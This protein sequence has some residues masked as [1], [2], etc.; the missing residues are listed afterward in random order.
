MMVSFHWK[1]QSTGISKDMVVPLISTRSL[2]DGTKLAQTGSNRISQ[3]IRIRIMIISNSGTRKMFG[4]SPKQL[5][6]CR[7]SESS[8]PSQSS[9]LKDFMARLYW[10]FSDSETDGDSSIKLNNIVWISFNSKSALQSMLLEHL[11]LWQ[12]VHELSI[13]LISR[14]LPGRHWKYQ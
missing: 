1:E 8:R 2:S 11:A 5:S 6:K 12:T 4:T 3:I 9:V 14:I 13:L 7:M 10:H